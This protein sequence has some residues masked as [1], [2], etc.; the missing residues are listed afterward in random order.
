MDDETASKF[1]SSLVKSIQ[2]LCNGYI[3][4]A[5]SI[6][7]IGHIHL[8]ID[9]G[10]KFNYILS[11][12]VNKSQ[13]EAATVF[14]SHS[15][16]SQRPA[17]VN[18]K[19][20]AHAQTD[21]AEAQRKFQ[22]SRKDDSEPLIVPPLQ[23]GFS[24]A[25]RDSFTSVRSDD[26]VLQSSASRSRRESDSSHSQSASFGSPATHTSQSLDRR[27]KLRSEVHSSTAT[28]PSSKRSRAG[29]AGSVVFTKS[30]FE[31]IEVKEEPDDDDAGRFFEQN[32]SDLSAAQDISQPDFSNLV[33]D[34]LDRVGQL[35]GTS[36]LT[37]SDAQQLRGQQPYPLMLHANQAAAAGQASTS[38]PLPGPSDP[39]GGQT[40]GGSEV[41][42][43]P[44]ALRER[45]SGNVKVAD[46]DTDDEDSFTEAQ[47]RSSL[48][49]SAYKRKLVSFKTSQARER[50][51]Q[52]EILRLKIYRANLSDEKVAVCR[53]KGRIRQH[54]YLQRKRE[55]AEL[56]CGLTRSAAEKKKLE[57]KRLV[58]DREKARLA[59]RE[60]R[61]ARTEEQ[62][63][64][65]NTRG[66]SS[67]QEAVGAFERDT[68]LPINFAEDMRAMEREKRRLYKRRY[69]AA[70]SEEQREENNRRNRQQAV[71][72]WIRTYKN[73][74]QQQIDTA[75]ELI[76]QGLSL[77][78]AA[79]QSGV[80][81]TTILRRT[82]R[83]KDHEGPCRGARREGRLS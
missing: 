14:A 73:Y 40:S 53:E 75:L 48:P 70:L 62:K 4:F 69:R 16:H 7:V 10:L 17:S 52:S 79:M 12:E 9:S 55:A 34:S 67:G 11:E 42:M 8:N 54:R 32:D 6:E 68:E 29:G 83:C 61:A 3:D 39:Q 13:N 59:M 43:P 38:V 74:T 51:R 77:N 60:R 81:E 71:R 72:G 78:R 80:P 28:E 82:W 35:E 50:W 1:V 44:Y 37:G 26:D 18:S 21:K 56:E 49:L 25:S 66:L 33:A 27:R 47:S 36:L 65:E 19:K 63:Q 20:T 15:Y 5:S 22:V 45:R 41:P 31:V 23:P 30:E 46:G 58:T 76:H 2:S 57:K 24:P 64:A